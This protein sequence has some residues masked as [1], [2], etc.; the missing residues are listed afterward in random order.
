MAFSL[1]LK[2]KEAVTEGTFQ[3]EPTPETQHGPM[4][5]LSVDRM[6]SGIDQLKYLSLCL[7]C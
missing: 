6:E 5:L 3:V 1:D 4:S 7:Y 2:D